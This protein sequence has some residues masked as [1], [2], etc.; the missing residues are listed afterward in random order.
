M[1]KNELPWG[2]EDTIQNLKTIKEALMEKAEKTNLDGKAKSDTEEIAF[3]F[4]RAIA[5][6]EE[7]QKYRALGTVEGLQELTRKGMAC[8]Q[9]AWE[10][11]VAISQLRDLGLSLGEKTDE[12]KADMETGRR[13]RNIMEELEKLERIPG[14][15]LMSKQEHLEIVRDKLGRLE[16][17]PI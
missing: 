7:N 9:V 4:N 10:R 3:D 1:I 13:I 6:L 8:G 2:V 17:K 14:W 15:A 11:D 16:K 12:A 5:A